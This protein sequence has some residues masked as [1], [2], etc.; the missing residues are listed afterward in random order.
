MLEDRRVREAEIAEDRRRREIENEE[1]MRGMREQI[2]MLQQLVTERT[3]TTRRSPN[4]CEGMRLTRL[5]DQDDIEAYLLTFE[6]MMQ[7]YEVDRPRWTYRLAP[8]LTGKAQQAYAALSITDASDYD[9]LKT[10]ILRRYNINEETYRRQFRSA[11]LKKG[12]TPRELVIRLRDLVK[13]WGRECG[14]LDA[15]FDLMV[16]E[17]LLNCLPEE[18]RVWIRERKP[19]DSEE[20]GELAE[21][22]L[23]ARDTSEGESRSKLTKERRPA[24]PSNCPRCGLA[25]HWASDC[26]KPRERREG[27]PNSN[28]SNSSD[29]SKKQERDIYCFTCKEKGHM[30]FKCPKSSGLYCE[31]SEPETH[32]ETTDVC[33]S[34][35]VNGVMVGDIILDTGASRTLVRE[36]LVPPCTIK[37]G[38][39]TIRCA[40]GD[41]IT[42]PLA[43]VK[44]SVGGEELN[45]RAA[46]SKTLPASVLLGR[47]VPELM[48]LL[49]NN[50]GKAT[51]ATPA[52]AL[53]ATT[54]AQARQQ[55]REKIETEKR[56]QTSGAVPSSM[57]GTEKD[58][59][60]PGMLFDFDASLFSGSRGRPR[61]TRSEKRRGRQT[62][63]TEANGT[64][65]PSPVNISAEEISCLQAE[66]PT[67][68]AVRKSA[69]GGSKS[70]GRGYFERE[71]LLYRRY[72]PPGYE[73]GEE[74]SRAIEQLVLPKPCRGPCAANGT[75][76]S[77]RRTP[78]E[79]Q[80][81][82]PYPPAVLLAHSL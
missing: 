78:G 16:K 24:P 7:A 21:A 63:A 38:E 50:G 26:P 1:R 54:R 27:N 75:Q 44:I 9:T 29:R 67:L 77:A 37:D 43:S 69:R 58:A 31:E 28:P 82:Q 60:T 52:L 17:Q 56:E 47:D 61:L 73:Q 6:R 35:Y 2:E 23:Q 81:D 15:L 46:V 39:V 65:P 66:D 72:I 55:H 40:H 12:E 13:K 8:Q 25:G 64:T 36:D 30:S 41:N 4:D 34:G 62:H 70:A 19:K 20:A 80:N 76:Y 51:T 74:E 14:T 10:A 22:F 71:G 3:T 57:D 45:V 68:E 18:V 53:A 5:S 11:K 59:D 42:Y 32:T 33:R 48:G 49:G 79:K